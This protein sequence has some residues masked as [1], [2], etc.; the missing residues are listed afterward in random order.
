[1]KK[2]LLAMTV[3][4][5]ML[6]GTQAVMADCG[7]PQTPSCNKPSCEDCAEKVRRC[8][9]DC[10][11][12]K[13]EEI[14]C[15][16]NLDSCQRDKAMAIEDRYDDDLECLGDKIKN[17]HD[18]LCDK[19]HASCLDKTAVKNQEKVLK[20][21]LKDMKSKLKM[22]DKDFNEILNKE[23]KSEYRKIKRELKFRAKHSMKYCCKCKNK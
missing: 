9:S 1:M 13:R 7:C 5:A 11:D 23:Q 19:L 18:C 3:S 15:R 6:A 10:R 12:Q 4:F 2:L 17:D 22:V 8:Y 14:Y 20:K 16:L 21:D